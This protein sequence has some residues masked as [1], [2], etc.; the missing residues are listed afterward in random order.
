MMRT[1][2]GLDGPITLLKVDAEGHEYGFVSD[3]L[4][5]ADEDLPHQILMEIHLVFGDWGPHLLRGTRMRSFG[6]VAAFAM[7]WHS[8]GYRLV[9]RT[10][11]VHKES[12]WSAEL[13]L[14]RVSG[15]R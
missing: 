5:S 8:R 4:A 15:C 10:D 3:L 13:T 9:W 12:P 7:L 1:E 11:N 14:I 6:E 2:Y